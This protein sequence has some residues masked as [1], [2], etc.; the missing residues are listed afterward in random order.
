MRQGHKGKATSPDD[1]FSVKSAGTAL[2]CN[3][4]F[5]LYLQISISRY[6]VP[7]KTTLGD[8]HLEDLQRKSSGDFS[9]K[10]DN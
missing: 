1:M 3:Y 6:A 10:P 5:P 4:S 7:L 9:M 8:M 2:L